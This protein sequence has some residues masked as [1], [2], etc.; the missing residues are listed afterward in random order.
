MEAGLKAKLIAQINEANSLDAFKAFLGSCPGSSGSQGAAANPGKISKKKRK[1]RNSPKQQVA[2]QPASTLAGPCKQNGKPY[3][4]LLDSDIECSVG[5]DDASGES[6]LEG[7]EF[8]QQRSRKKIRLDKKKVSNSVGT[9]NPSS[10]G[11][12]DQRKDKISPL[13]LEGLSDMEKENPMLIRKLINST[14]AAVVR[15]VKT[16]RGTVLVF[17]SSLP[18][19][20]ELLQLKLRDGLTLRPTKDRKVAKTNLFVIIQGVHPSIDEKEIGDELQST[21]KRIVS[22]KLNGTPT[23]K[24]KMECQS[25]EEKTKS[26]KQ[27]VYIGL[28]HYQVTEYIIRY[29]VTQ[30]FKCQNYGHISSNCTQDI[31]CPKCAEAHAAIDCTKQVVLCANCGGA[32]ESRSRDCPRY[33]QEVTKNETK[34]LS[35]AHAVKKGGDRVDCIRLASSLAA[36]LVNIIGKRLQ[37][38]INSSDIC[39]DVAESISTCYKVDI[40]GEYVHSIAFARRQDGSSQSLSSQNLSSQNLSSRGPSSQS[41]SSENPSS[42]NPSSQTQ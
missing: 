17:P 4:N 27:G 29:V 2:S 22:A 9:V 18:S 35:Y 21:C 25:M 12:T 5:P 42:E 14:S 16:P 15:T 32:H 3:N 10:S 20:N 30:C 36:T 7:G 39:K 23:W 19:R 38:R 40:K 8:T 11:T 24:V 26:I 13:V 34:S 37:L 31:K 1:N 33:T 41:G 6:E 28:R